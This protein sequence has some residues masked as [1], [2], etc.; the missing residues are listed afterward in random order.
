MYIK[1]IEENNEIQLPPQIADLH[2]I[3]AGSMTFQ[4]GSWE[5][6]V[7]V[8]VNPDFPSDII[9][10]PE[11]WQDLFTIP[12][13]LS[14]NLKVKGRTLSLGPVIAFIVFSHEK[15]MN[16]SSLNK[17]R[18]YFSDYLNVGGLIF[19]CAWNSIDIKNKLIQGYYFDPSGSSPSSQ[20]KKGTFPYPG[21]AYNRTAMPKAVFD[22]L[23]SKM[24]NCIFN[25]FSRG[26][27]NKWELYKRLSPNPKLLPYL[28]A[29]KLLTD[30]SVL[31]DMLDKYHSI[32]IKPTKGTLSRGVVRADQTDSGWMVA[33]PS[34][35]QASGLSVMH[36]ESLSK[37]QE[38]FSGLKSKEYLAQQAIKMQRYQ[39]RPIDFRVIMQKDETGTW[40]CTGIFGKFGRS[41]S[42]ITNFSRAG[43]LRSGFDAFQLAFSMN[44]EE[45]KGKIE[46]MKEITFQ[47]CDVFDQYGNYGD[48]GIDL[49]VDIHGKVWILEVN[50]L[51]TYHRFPLHLKD[52]LLYKKVVTQPF[53]YAKYLAGFSE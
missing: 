36:L 33:I 12:D 16:R 44:E 43:F 3:S 29:T 31:S 7:Q 20:W 10:L 4:F 38:W 25:S 15:K 19:I 26:S 8:S 46:K 39:D 18:S 21:A 17:H 9:G 13:T 35:K 24:G 53:K 30:I 40:G 52:K 45:A 49:M 2:G 27:F 11:H 41:G 37:Q 5:Q 34:K 51:D 28:P 42:I 14:Y 48:L 47:I 1:W 23:S 6:M 50:T 32:Y 22:D